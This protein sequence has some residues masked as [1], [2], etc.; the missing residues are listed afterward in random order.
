[1]IVED[2]GSSIHMSTPA[3]GY[4]C[5]SHSFF[6]KAWPSDVGKFF[7]VYTWDYGVCDVGE[8]GEKAKGIEF[9]GSLG[10]VY[11]VDVA[12]AEGTVMDCLYAV[13]GED[14]G[15]LG[16]RGRTRI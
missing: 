10:H 8:G 7:A 4:A 12:E 9:V 6:V 14:M 11:N 15:E 5:G 3:A 16:A 2:R 1:M 13:F